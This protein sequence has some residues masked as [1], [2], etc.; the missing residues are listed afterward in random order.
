MRS[1][2]KG[3]RRKGRGRGGGGTGSDRSAKAKAG[4]LRKSV[5]L[6]SGRVV[7]EDIGSD[8]ILGKLAQE[9]KLYDA[10]ILKEVEKAVN[11]EQ[12]TEALMWK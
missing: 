9:L 4:L 8:K 12:A 1:W 11:P 3:R 2:L 6:I 10:Q 5:R 7:T